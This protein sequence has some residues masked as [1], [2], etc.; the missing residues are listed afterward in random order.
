MVAADNDSLSPDPSHPLVVSSASIANS[1]AMEYDSCDDD[2][3]SS[4]IH[5]HNYRL[6]ITHHPHHQRTITHYSLFIICISSQCAYVS[7]FH[8]LSRMFVENYSGLL[9]PNSGSITASHDQQERLD[10]L[11]P[12]QKKR[13]R[14]RLRTRSQTRNPSRNR[15]EDKPWYQAPTFVNRDSTLGEWQFGNYDFVVFSTSLHSYVYVAVHRT[16]HQFIPLTRLELDITKRHAA[17]H[18]GLIYVVRGW[19]TIRGEGSRRSTWVYSGKT[20]CSNVEEELDV[21]W[22]NANHMNHKWRHSTILRYPKQW[23]RIPVKSRTKPT[24][25]LALY[26]STPSKAIPATLP[27]SQSKTIPAALSPP[28]SKAIQSALPPSQSKAILT[29]LPPSQSKAIQSALPPSQQDPP[30]C[31]ADCLIKFFDHVGLTSFRD[32]FKS[33]RHKNPSFGRCTNIIRSMRKFGHHKHGSCLDPLRSGLKSHVLYLF[34][35]RA[36]DIRTNDVDNSHS[37]CIFNGLIYDANFDRPLDLNMTNLSIVCVGGSCWVY[38]KMVRC[39]SFTPTKNVK[40]F[41]FKRLGSKK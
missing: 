31:T 33:E 36:V 15:L 16:S 38:D 14:T 41:I 2:N 4:D 3:R 1:V 26:P 13:V 37:I 5:Y 28:Q 18:A 32:K 21:H 34:Q 40:R 35:I 39:A 25:R 19:T 23:F 30:A 24:P 12:P 20:Y 29:A 11:S 8:L 27:P 22:L 9:H 6:V 10:D 7:W 17:Q